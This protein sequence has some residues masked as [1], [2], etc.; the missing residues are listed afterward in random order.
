[1]EIGKFDLLAVFPVSSGLVDSVK[2][3][4]IVKR[5]SVWSLTLSSR[6]QTCSYDDF[7]FGVEG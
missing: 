5:L 3:V 4:N 7:S 2:N 1:M 6:Y